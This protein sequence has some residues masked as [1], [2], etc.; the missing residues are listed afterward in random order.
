METIA[1]ALPVVVRFDVCCRRL[2]KATVYALPPARMLFYLY[3]SYGSADPLI[4]FSANPVVY[5]RDTYRFEGYMKGFLMPSPVVFRL[6]GV[7]TK[8]ALEY[9]SLRGCKCV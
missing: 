3:R 8:G 4:Y 1:L 9:A 6:E 5:N 2:I 7:G